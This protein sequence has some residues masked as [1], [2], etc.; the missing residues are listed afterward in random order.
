[1]SRSD[2][3]D[4]VIILSD[5]GPNIRYGL[6]KAGFIRLTCYAHI[7]HNLVTAMLQ[8][9]RVGN[10]IKLSSKLSAYMRNSGLNSKLRTSLKNYTC[11]RWNSVYIMIKEIIKNYQAV[12]DLLCKKQTSINEA[13]LRQNM[14][15]ETTLLDLITDLSKTDLITLCEFLEP[16]KVMTDN[17]EGDKYMT[18][19][20]VWPIYLKLFMALAETDNDIISEVDN[21]PQLF[22]TEMKTI[23]R[24]YMAK[25]NKDFAPTFY[26]KVAVILHP[27]MKKLHIISTAERKQ[28]Y[29]EVNNYIQSKSTPINDIVENTIIVQNLSEN[30]S[31]LNGQNLLDSFIHL[32]SFDDVAIVD[33]ELERYLKHPISTNITNISD[34]WIAN[35]SKYPNLFKLYLKVSC[36]PATTASSER[37]FSTAGY[38]VND[39]RSTILPNNVNDLIVARNSFS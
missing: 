12:Y 20:F 6:I 19:H 38:I 30:S 13:R 21:S 16:F 23:G 28:L 35:Q 22:V 32:D 34:W 10:I 9:S 37:D 36:V 31:K 33:T 2:V 14:Q 4:Y 8:Q 39:K 18:L 11:T 1:M 15:P 5:R 7:I 29:D 26:H 27:P 3:L 17:L 25:N 24:A